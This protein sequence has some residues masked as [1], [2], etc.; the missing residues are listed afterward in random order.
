M[1]LR[2]L[3]GTLINTFPT[4]AGLISLALVVVFGALA[5]IW[6]FIDGT[7][8]ARA[9]PDPDRRRDLAMRWLLAGLIAGG[10]SGLVTWLISLFYPGVYAE[11]L[12]PEI[13]T[14]AAFTALVVFVPAMFAVA[15]GRQIVDRRR[16][17]DP[18]RKEWESD[19]FDA[20]R[21][22]GYEEPT[23]E[24]AMAG[25]REESWRQ[26]A[27]EAVREVHENVQQRKYDLNRGSDET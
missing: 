27:R 6:G 14:L 4:K 10:L 1:L 19:V 25:R 17:D 20:V 22:D 8:D 11:G 23:D 5:L 7:A 21:A 24:V 9:N 18:R 26:D 16:P 2:L 15:V 12:I 13:S 3:Q